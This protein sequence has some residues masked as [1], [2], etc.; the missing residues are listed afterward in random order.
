MADYWQIQERI[1]RVFGKKVFFIV[2][3]TRSGTDWLCSSLDAHPE[4]FCK[5]E[6]H[7]T[8]VFYPLLGRA[9][10]QHNEHSQKLKGRLQAFGMQC[11]ASDFTR[12]ELEFLAGTAIG[13]LLDRWAGE[14]DVKC[15]G[16]KTPEHALSMD[17]LD[18]MVPQAKFI[19]VIRDGRDEAVSSWDYSMQMNPQALTKKHP[20][21]SGFVEAFVKSWSG[22]VGKARSLG[23][24]LG[25]RYME[26]HCED[27]LIEP[28]AV[29]N[30][31]LPF[32]GLDVGPGEISL[33]A[34]KA[35]QAAVADN[36]IGRWRDRFDE[37]SQNLFQRHAGELMKLL[38][39]D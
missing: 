29:F 11:E 2:G 20:K 3:L 12:E 28:D 17:L 35:R 33:C 27:L 30:K 34:T 4:I 21:F 22:G 31:L 19:H 38:E 8:D 25:R 23:R 32:L 26:V 1:N 18:R 5:G 14:A 36:G 39:Y 7:I 37:E 16:E 24:G 6:G 10:G 13:L 9:V 15:I